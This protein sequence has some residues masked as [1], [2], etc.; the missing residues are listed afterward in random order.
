[1]KTTMIASTSSAAPSKR[2]DRPYCSALALATTST[3]FPTAAWASQAGVQRRLGVVGQFR[4]QQPGCFAGVGD[5]DARPSAVGQHRDPPSRGCGLG[6][7]HGGDVEHVLQVPARITPAWWNSASTAASPA[8]SAAVCEDAARRPGAGTAGLHRHD[9]LVPADAPRDPGEPA[10]VGHR[11]QVGQHDVGA[12]V[13]V[14][15]QQ[16]VVG[17]QVGGVADRHEAA[18]AERRAGEQGE[19]GQPETAE[20]VTNASPARRGEG[21]AEGRVEPGIGSAVEQPH[22]VGPDQPHPGGA[23]AAAQFILQG[24]ARAAGLGEPGGD[25]AHRPDSRAGRP[26]R[27]PRPPAVRAPPPPPG[28]AAAGRRAGPG[29]RPPP[30]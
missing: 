26:G 30:G 2:R 15:V 3:G 8:A 29:R 10:G 12:G 13:L 23:G 25:H 17:C 18:D 11:L 16:Q 14:P 9:G 22:A 6:G 28:P 1:M 27:R 5:Q 20:Y 21:E 19:R 4:H 7:D 24:P